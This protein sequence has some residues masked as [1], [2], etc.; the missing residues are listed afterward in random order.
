[1]RDTKLL[2]SHSAKLMREAKEK[3]LNRVLRKEVN[4]GANGTQEYVIK[5]GANTGKV[6]K[7]FQKRQ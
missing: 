3:E 2:Q 5:K 6:A 4:T 7:G 1:M